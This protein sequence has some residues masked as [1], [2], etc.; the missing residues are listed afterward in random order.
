MTYL[1]TNKLTWATSWENLVLP[2]A[3]NKVQISLRICQPAHLRSLIS[4][5]VDRCLDSIISIL[6]ISKISRPW[7][8]SVAEQAGLSITWSQIPKTDFLMRRHVLFFSSNMQ[9]Y[10]YTADADNS[11]IT[12]LFLLHM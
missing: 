3:N 7:L 2:Y 6:A 5:F 8:V 1:G 12:G 9:L 11:F 10:L 4:A